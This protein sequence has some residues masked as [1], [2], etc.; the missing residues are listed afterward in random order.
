MASRQRLSGARGRAAGVRR[1]DVYGHQLS[2]LDSVVAAAV[3]APVFAA[4][5]KVVVL[6]RA[7]A[8]QRTAARPTRPSARHLGVR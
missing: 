2:S 7:T 6:P 3:V 1:V 5:D 8:E 4:P